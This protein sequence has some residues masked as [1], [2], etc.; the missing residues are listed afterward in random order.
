M[1]E[2]DERDGTRAA[3]DEGERQV[4]SR[5]RTILLRLLY[6]A[7]IAAIVGSFFWQIAH[8]ECPVP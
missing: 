7:A 8:G 4:P 2:I 6:L 5:R 1:S 3:E